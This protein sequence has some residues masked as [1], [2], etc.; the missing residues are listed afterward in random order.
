MGQKMTVE[1]R[2]ALKKSKAIDR[3]IAEAR[4]DMEREVKLLLLGTGGSGKSTIAK[5]MHIIYLNGFGEKQRDEFRHLI[6]VNLVENMQNI[7]IGARSLG[8]PYSSVEN[9]AL[10]EEVLTWNVQDENN[11]F[12]FTNEHLNKL[13]LLWRNEPAT[14]K[15]FMKQNEFQLNDSAK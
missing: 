14:L 9:D 7:I 15:A 5:Q 4:K 1:A 3:E 12:P 6:T 8:I 13:K 10:A 11:P 2:A